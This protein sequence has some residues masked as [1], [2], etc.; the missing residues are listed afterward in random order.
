M[1][2]VTLKMKVLGNVEK[3]EFAL[4]ANG[5]VVMFDDA[6]GTFT[7]EHNLTSYQLAKVLSAIGYFKA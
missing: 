1:K 3:R 7:D 5:L 2:T 4:D 6:T